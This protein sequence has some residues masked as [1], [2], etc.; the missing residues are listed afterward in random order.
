MTGPFEG[1]K[2]DAGGR[3]RRALASFA[4]G[5][6]ATCGTAAIEFAMIGSVL[7]TLLL[8]GVDLG[9]AFYSDMQVQTSAQ[10]G[11]EYA[12]LH[13][14][15]SGSITSAVTNATSASGISA[16]PAPSQFCGCVSGTAINATTCGS[17][18]AD[19]MTAGTYVTVTATRSYTTLIP[20]PSLPASFTQA[21]T[22][23]VRIQ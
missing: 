7:V 4:T 13:G 1:R 23:T 19:G 11:A 18:C 16:S 9:M 22:S 3:L 21:A 6:G 14:F 17:V 12:V 2:T 8:A 10:S 15:N 5:D 20:Y